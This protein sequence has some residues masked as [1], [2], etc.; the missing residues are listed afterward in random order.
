MQLLNKHQFRGDE[1]VLDIGCGDGKITAELAKRVR[2]GRVVGIDPSESMIT[3]ARKNFGAIK[4]I[5]FCHT[6]AENFSTGSSFDLVV[7]FSAFQYINDPLK[8]F[9]NIST[10]LK[11]G[12]ALIVLTAHG[13]DPVFSEVMESKKWKSII[14]NKNT[15][16][17]LTAEQYGKLLAQADF[18]LFDVKPVVTKKLFRP[19]E[20]IAFCLGWIPYVT[21]LSGD[22]ANDLAK[23]LMEN[24]KR[25][26]E[27]P[28]PSG[29]LL[30]S[31]PLV[32]LT[33]TK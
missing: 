18:P 1:T 6:S 15:W 28:D 2:F 22:A 11:P 4:N 32:V 12:G 20:F 9:K 25:H 8:V 13:N 17:A 21:G 33:A 31:T 27:H 23:D 16:H 29:N 19:E 30:L 5:E 14:A 7:S 3:H 26:M 24:S 10:I